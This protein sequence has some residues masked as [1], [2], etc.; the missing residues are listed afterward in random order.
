MVAFLQRSNITLLDDKYITIHNRFILA[1][2]LDG[3][4][5]GGY[6]KSQRKPVE[7]VLAGANTALPVVVMEHNPARGDEYKPGDADVILSG[8]THKGQIFPANLFTDLIYT[9][10]YGYYQE[11]ANMPHRIVTSGAGIWGMPM[12]VGTDCEVVKVILH[13]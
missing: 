5:I 10:D 13:S 6:N 9:V 1:G 3:S 4:P 12:R 2:R 8:H 11:S 7:Q